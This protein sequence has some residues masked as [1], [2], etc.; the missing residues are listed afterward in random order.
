MNKV[1]IEM[2][3]LFSKEK[4][5]KEKKGLIT[6]SEEEVKGISAMIKQANN[7]FDEASR[8]KL[9]EGV[10]I[11]NPTTKLSNDRLMEDN[12]AGI[13]NVVNDAYDM[14]DQTQNIVAQLVDDNLLIDKI[15]E[16]REEIDADVATTNKLTKIQKNQELLKRLILIGLAALLTFW[17]IILLVLKIR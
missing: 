14:K 6:K 2:K 3:G 8:A 4:D 12:L 5:S 11:S 13:N 9:F 7:K 16:A 17:D 15:G 10:D 1:L